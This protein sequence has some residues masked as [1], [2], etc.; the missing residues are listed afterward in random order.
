MR[1]DFRKQDG[2]W[3]YIHYNQFFVASSSEKYKL[4]V[5]G[6][7]GRDG[8]YF[9]GGNEPAKN[10]MFSTFDRDNDLW[11]SNCVVHSSYQSG[12]WFHRCVDINPNAPRPYYNSPNTAEGMEMKIRLKNCVLH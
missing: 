8:D 7:T 4:T 5:G 12:W 2:S 3:S 11:E 6:Y 1:V 10:R 9:V